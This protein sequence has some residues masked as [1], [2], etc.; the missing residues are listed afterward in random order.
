MLF[1]SI[2]AGLYFCHSKGITA[3]LQKTTNEIGFSLGGKGYS[4][5]AGGGYSWRVKELMEKVKTN[6]KK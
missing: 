1:N 2:A 6:D 3:D 4:F 5:G